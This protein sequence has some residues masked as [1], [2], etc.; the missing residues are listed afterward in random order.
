M[1]CEARG[2]IIPSP[3]WPFH[4]QVGEFLA[5]CAL[6]LGVRVTGLVLRAILYANDIILLA[7]SAQDLQALLDV[8]E[9]FYTAAGMRPNPKKCEVGVY[10]D[11]SWPAQVVR[12]IV[13]WTLINAP[14]NKSLHY[15]YLGTKSLG[16]GLH[17]Q[18]LE[19]AD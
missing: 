5:A 13:Q 18:G 2:P 1:G 7:E 15:C 6:T 9:D 8:L 11:A 3:L 14:V 19:A 17:D 16:S 12:A 4:R 10:N